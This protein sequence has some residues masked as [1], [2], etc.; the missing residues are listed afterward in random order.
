MFQPSHVDGRTLVILRGRN[1]CL[2]PQ[3]SVVAC[4]QLEH[5]GETLTLV[6]NDQ[7]RVLS[8]QELAAVMIVKP[9]SR[10]AECRGFDLFLI[11]E[12]VTEPSVAPDCG[13]I[14]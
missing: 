11:Q 10:I 1:R 5:D 8:D 3:L 6:G 2:G 9:D 13:G 12:D 14:T 7:A 4:G